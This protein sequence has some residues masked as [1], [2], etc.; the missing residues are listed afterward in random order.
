MHLFSN[1]LHGQIF[2]HTFVKIMGWTFFPKT[3]AA[4]LAQLVKRRSAERKVAGS[5]PGRSNTQGL[6][7]TEENNVLSLLWHL[8][9]VRHSS[10]LG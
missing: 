7:I 6:K 5:S 1:Q 2:F 3:T 4:R 8:Q 10:L 9:M